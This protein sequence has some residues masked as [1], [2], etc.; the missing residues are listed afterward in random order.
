MEYASIVPK[1]LNIH[2]PAVLLLAT[3]LWDV[4]PLSLIAGVCLSLWKR[5]VD[6]SIT[7]KTKLVAAAQSL[8]SR[9]SRVT[10][11]CQK[12][13]EKWTYHQ[14]ESERGQRATPISDEVGL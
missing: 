2:W 10:R 11:L 14:T 7:R 4:V 12:E 1:S 6:V 3:P 9:C 8:P 13:R 5:A